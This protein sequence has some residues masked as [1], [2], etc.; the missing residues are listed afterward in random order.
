MLTCMDRRLKPATFLQQEHGE[1][2]VVRNAGNQIP[3]AKNTRSLTS[4]SVKS[5]S[6]LQPITAVANRLQST[7]CVFTITCVT[8]SFAVIQ[9]VG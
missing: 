2:F 3:H 8:P 5:E 6:I 9:I 4:L 1:M 7:L